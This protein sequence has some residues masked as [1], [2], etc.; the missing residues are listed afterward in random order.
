MLMAG[1]AR[2]LERG[3]FDGRLSR[4]LASALG[5]AFAR[6]LVRPGRVP[7]GIRVVCVGGATLGGSGKTRVAIATASLLASRGARVAIIGHAYRGRVRSPKVVSG[8]DPV[9]EVGDE[10][11][12]CARA[13]PGLEVVVGPSRQAAIDFAAGRSPDVLVFDGPLALRGSAALSL[14]S[15]DAAR[16]WGAGQVFPAGDLRA[17]RED[18]LA[19]AHHVVSVE[20]TPAR[21]RWP[22]GKIVPLGSLRSSSIG[23]F[24][25]LA[26][27][28]RLIEALARAGIHPVRTLSAV[29]HGP[30][31]ALSAGRWVAT[32]KCALHVPAGTEVG[33]L[34]S[35]LCL[36][37][38]VELDLLSRCLD[39]PN[40]S[41]IASSQVEGGF[42][43]LGEGT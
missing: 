27:P 24:T 43:S 15:V 8:D 9:E 39:P 20:A 31:P 14:L 1:A 22:D 42:I 41:A 23:L 29:D 28:D 38:A 5:P 32:A 18:L 35:D 16:P 11:I 33:I 25:A 17:P 40:E 12:V 34:E 7:A 3:R 21:V 4:A 6:G 37:R 2:A 30:S 10:A 19:L 36:P 26:R 13:L